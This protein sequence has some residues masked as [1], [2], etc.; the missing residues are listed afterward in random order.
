LL[1]SQPGQTPNKQ[2]RKNRKYPSATGLENSCSQTNQFSERKAHKINKPKPTE[3]YI[4]I[5][6]K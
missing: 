3:K 1:A 6:H 2:T 5:A 4:K